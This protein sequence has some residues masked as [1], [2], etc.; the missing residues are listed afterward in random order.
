M[1]AGDSSLGVCGVYAGGR[2]QRHR[3]GAREIHESAGPLG[4]GYAGIAVSYRSVS[5]RAAVCRKGA[6]GSTEQLSA[7]LTWR[8]AQCLSKT[9]SKSDPRLHVSRKWPLLLFLGWSSA[10]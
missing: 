8:S 4:R 7:R 3:R 6:Q 9:T 1:D 2:R 10:L 5:I